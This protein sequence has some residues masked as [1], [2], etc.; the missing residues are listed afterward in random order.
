MKLG[1]VIGHMVHEAA[2][3]AL[4]RISDSHQPWPPKLVHA[5]FDLQRQ[6]RG[7]APKWLERWYALQ[8]SKPS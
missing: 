7:M 8:G 4:T 1:E 3:E 6:L 2:G 5:T